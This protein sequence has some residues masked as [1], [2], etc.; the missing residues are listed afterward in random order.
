MSEQD[1]NGTQIRTGFQQVSRAA[2]AKGVIMVL[3]IWVPLRSVIAITHA[4]AQR[5]SLFAI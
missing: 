3:T 4:T 2:M 5:S 1:L